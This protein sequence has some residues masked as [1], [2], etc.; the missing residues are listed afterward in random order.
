MCPER[1]VES[2]FFDDGSHVC[3]WYRPCW[4]A[5]W[6]PTCLARRRGV[7][8]TETRIE[9][10]IEELAD[11]K[12]KRAKINVPLEGIAYYFDY[13]DSMKVLYGWSAQRSFRSLQ[14]TS[15]RRAIGGLHSHRNFAGAYVEEAERIADRPR[16]APAQMNKLFLFPS[17]ARILCTTPM[18]A[19]GRLF[20]G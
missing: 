15:G 13:V 11:K 18:S 5:S 2:C 8:A 14:D 1:F 7:L 20:T 17:T 9:E 4:V 19:L 10:I 6:L 3:W 16:F 12:A